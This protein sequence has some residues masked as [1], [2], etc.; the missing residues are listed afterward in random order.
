[1]KTFT[2]IAIVGAGPYGLSLA[3]HLRELKIDHRIFGRPMSTWQEHMPKSM[4]L[5]SDGFAS[6]L[7]D[8]ADAF[9]IRDYCR[10]N[11]IAYDDTHLPVSLD[12]FVAYGLA[13]QQR[14]A[15]GLDQQNIARVENTAQGFELELEDG[16]LVG[17]RYVVLAVGITHFAFVPSTLEGLSS[18]FLSH[19]SQHRDG[20]AF[21]GRSVTVVG[22]GSSSTDLA[23]ELNESGASVSI[24]TRRPEIQFH[25]K[26]SAAKRAF[27]QELRH[28]TSGLGPGWRSRILCDAPWMF[29]MLPEKTRLHIVRNY[30]GPS[31]GWPMRER[32]VGR[33]PIHSSSTIEKT[34]PVD[35]KLY[36]HLR[37]ADGAE[38][39]HITDHVIAA[40]GYKP[41]LER[42]QFLSPE[43][44]RSIR[45]VDQAPV[46]S[47]SF[48]SNVRGLFFIGVSAANTFGPLMRFAVGAGFA[49][50]RV[51]KRIA[52]TVSSKQSVGARETA[53]AR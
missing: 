38:K 12:T 46:L 32:I 5:K 26:P 2:Q 19:S 48:E 1:V 53:N 4:M 45:T 40:T 21:K 24:V 14:F 13:F 9:P 11:G 16:N 30:L 41:L 15:P 49:A 51:T 10:R 6:N 34:V 8:P 29:R 44:R 7:F 20:S 28:P 17:A 18:E 47:R 42:L 37:K 36:V 3:A 33:V 23:A 35:G 31:A 39:V 25:N 27:W 43:L 52:D 50:R 22:G